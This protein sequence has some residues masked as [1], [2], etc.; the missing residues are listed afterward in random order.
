[1]YKLIISDLDG[2]LV[3]S[4][5]EVS[6][7]TKKIVHLLKKMGIHFIIATGRNL[8]GAKLIYDELNLNSE[9][10]CNNGSTI[11]NNKGELIFQRILDKNIVK[12]IFEKSIVEE[13]T[14]FGTYGSQVYIGEGSLKTVNDFIEHPLQ[15]P[16]ELNKENISSFNF[17]KVVL[18]DKD[19]DKLMK[20]SKL[21]NNYKEVNAFVSQS[22]YLDIVHFE[23]SKGAALKTLAKSK[24]IDLKH[25]IA[26]GDAFNDYEMLRVAGKGLVMLNGFEELKKEFQTL[27]FTNDENGVARYLAE[28][29]S[30]LDSEVI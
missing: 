3:N 28:A 10:V 5:K 24:N 16:I 4:N 20:L 21:F 1:M 27:D 11:Y 15:N 25:T 9:I 12:N 17:E 22:N 6:H 26:F 8:S 2:T 19:N 18:M 29:F 14:F 23:T 13:C 30:I 7:Y